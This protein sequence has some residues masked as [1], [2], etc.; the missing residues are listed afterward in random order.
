ML[1]HVI[2]QYSVYIF[3]LKR[4]SGRRKVQASGG[5]IKKIMSTFKAYIMLT[6]YIAVL[7]AGPYQGHN[8]K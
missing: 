6:L 1:P 8:K 4:G 7:T 2:M 5:G 3:I